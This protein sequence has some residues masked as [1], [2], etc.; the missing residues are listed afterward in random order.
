MMTLASWVTIKHLIEIC[1]AGGS[2]AVTGAEGIEEGVLPRIAEEGPASTL[3]AL[4]KSTKDDRGGMY[5][6][7]E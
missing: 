1:W 7:E 2:A 6:E 5:G 4:S 3:V